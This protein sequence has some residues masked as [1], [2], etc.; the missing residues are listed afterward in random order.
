MKKACA[1]KLTDWETSALHGESLNRV[2]TALPKCFCC[3]KKNHVP[4]KCFFRKSKCHGCQ[5]YGH[6]IK[7]CPEGFGNN[8]SKKTRRGKL[9]GKDDKQKKKKLSGMHNVKNDSEVESG[10]ES[11]DE[12]IKTTW[13]VFTLTDSGKKY[14]EIKVLVSIKGKTS[15]YGSGRRSCSVDYAGKCLEKSVV[16]KTSMKV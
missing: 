13:P 3:G 16:S 5:N 9:K 14:K 4:D 1:V 7:K 12:V 10:S 2:E 8:I 11:Q 6:I 15:K